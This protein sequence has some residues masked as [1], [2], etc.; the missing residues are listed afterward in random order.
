MTRVRENT[1][2]LSDEIGVRITKNTGEVYADNVRF[3]FDGNLIQ[4]PNKSI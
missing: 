1:F 2:E 3:V 4:S